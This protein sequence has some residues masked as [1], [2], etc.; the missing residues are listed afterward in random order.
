MLDKQFKFTPGK[1]E[2]VRISLL[3][4]FIL[5]FIL[6]FLKPFDMISY[7]PHEK[8]YLYF[9]YGLSLFF[10]HLIIIFVEDKIY[11]KQG[12][13]WYVKNEIFIKL[14]YFLIG[15][16]IIYFYHFLFVKTFQHPWTSFPAFVLN[17]TLPFFLMFLPLMVFYRNMK[18]KFYNE[19][20]EKV[21]FKGTNKSEK[22][23]LKR[24]DILFAR[25]ENNYVF[26]Y[27]IDGEI[28]KKIMLRNTLSKIHGQAPFFI[29]SHRSYLINPDNL[30]SLK[31]NTQNA[32]LQLRLFE[33]KI[34][35]S[36][37][38]YAKIKAVKTEV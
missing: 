18:G 12:K 19:A 6:F 34:P 30:L 16:L 33:E 21:L 17:Y 29:K 37:T 5:V 8:W 15:S 38:Y 20:E 25:S 27:Y 32:T 1:L 35:V 14:L 22:F 3:V 13:K 24:K 11:L 4:T 28:V 10:S 2:K 9:G 31:G 7:V 26:I 36:K 23:N